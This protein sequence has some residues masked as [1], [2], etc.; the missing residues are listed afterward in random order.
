VF[1]DLTFEYVPIPDGRNIDERK[2]G[3]T[4]D[5]W[6]GRLLVEYFP[7]SKQA[8]MA[9]QSI[10]FD[11][12]FHSFT[13]GDPTSPKASLRELSRGDMLVFYSGLQGYDFSSAPALYIIGY[14][15]V[16][17]V[18]LAT[19]RIDPGPELNHFSENFHVRHRQ[20]Y[21]KDSRNGL[22]LVKGGR[23]SRLL[24][25]AIKI[26]EIGRDVAGRPLKVLSTEMRKVFGDFG[27][28]NSFQR[29]PPRWVNH[30]LVAKAAELVRSLD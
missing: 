25:S 4:H 19:S 3:T 10:H 26:S 27:G 6:H 23:R 1:S 17:R 21:L 15:E 5:Q 29:S 16:E 24:R 20:V 13:Y 9:T 30:D 18:L 28:R 22:V 8:R 11:P 12:E 14:F 2:Y 7:T